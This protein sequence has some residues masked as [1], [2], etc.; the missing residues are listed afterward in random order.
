MIR[1]IPFP[2]NFREGKVKYYKKKKY[3]V[4][5]NYVHYKI[6]IQFTNR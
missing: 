5:I 1:S 4:P 3:K 2:F 6:C